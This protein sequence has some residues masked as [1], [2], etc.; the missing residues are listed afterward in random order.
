MRAHLAKRGFGKG[1]SFRWRGGSEITR[2]EGFSDAVFAFAI[3]LLV[4]SLEVPKTFNELAVGMRGFVAF[5]LAFAMLFIIWLQQYTFFRRYGL[6]DSWTIALNAFLLFVVLFFVYPLKF[7]FGWMIRMWTGGSNEIQLPNG[8]IEQIVGP[9]QAEQLMIVYGCG[10]IAVFGVFLLMYWHA[11]R[12]SG[13]LELDALELFDTRNSM[14]QHVV[15][16]A[17]GAVSLA[18]ALNGDPNW[19]GLTYV[20][21]SP[22]MTLHGI[23]M[24]RKRRPLEAVL[25]VL[26][27][28][29]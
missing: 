12:S 17:I 26:D 25:L 28:Q 27:Q 19:A 16:I 5:G 13:E 20:A 9:G 1:K 3:T 14:Q 7:L 15:N 29:H 22:A 18:F 8:Q 10:Y 11:W 2:I 4:V 23:W 24:G 21:V 6:Q